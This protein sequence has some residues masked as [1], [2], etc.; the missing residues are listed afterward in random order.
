MA[1]KRRKKIT[2]EQKRK[3]RDIVK[4]VGKTLLT[5]GIGAPLTALKIMKENPAAKKKMIN[6]LKAEAP[7]LLTGGIMKAPQKLAAAVS[8]AFQNKAAERAGMSMGE[9][10]D[11]PE[12]EREEIEQDALDEMQT[13]FD[14]NGEDDE[15]NFLD[16]ATLGVAIGAGKKLLGKIKE[17]RMAKGKG[18]FGK[19][20]KSEGPSPT[21][22]AAKDA[23]KSGVDE[24]ADL[25]KK[26][27]VKKMLPLIIGV[28]VLVVGGTIAAV[29][30]SRG[31]KG[32]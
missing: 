26:Q 19:K 28:A 5:G 7:H 12:E 31:S 14:T 32:K 30:M 11:L 3:R 23:I 10:E 25:R 2:P 15:E 20:N 4:K 24:Y 29:V 16:P 8:M 17:N 1:R 27:E 18:W 9:L 6:F 22:A 13:D 21:V